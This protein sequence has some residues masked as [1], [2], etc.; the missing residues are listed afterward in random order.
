M[1]SQSPTPELL[2]WAYRQGIFPM[3][4]PASGRIEYFSPDPR[5]ILPLEHVHVSKSLARRVRSGRFEIRSDTRFEQVMRECGASGR[6]QRDTWIDERLVVAYC[7]LHELGLAHSVEAWR[8][9]VLVGGL[10]GVHLGAAFFGESMFSRP[11]LGGTDASK[12]CL[13]WLVEGM[14]EAGFQLLDT[15]FSTPHLERFGALEIPRQR[16]L[17]LL[18]RALASDAPWVS[19]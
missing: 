7:G 11:E 2:V 12:V 18:E 8:D 14:R 16:Y 17:S 9:D 1:D 4:D 13:V 5:T 10:Y 15:Q 3:F 19:C 6:G